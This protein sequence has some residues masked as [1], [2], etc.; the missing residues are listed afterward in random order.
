MGSDCGSPTQHNTPPLG[1]Q[2]CCPPTRLSSSQGDCTK[3]QGRSLTRITQ[4]LPRK[5]SQWC[6]HGKSSG[7]TAKWT[8]PL[9]LLICQATRGWQPGLQL[10]PGKRSHPST[11]LSQGNV[12]W[13]SPLLWHDLASTKAQDRGG[14]DQIWQ[15]RMAHHCFPIF[16]TAL[17]AE[18]RGG[19][20]WY[21]SKRCSTCIYS[22]YFPVGCDLEWLT[23]ATCEG[24]LLAPILLES[25]MSHQ[26][27]HVHN[28]LTWG[29]APGDLV[30]CF[31]Q[32]ES[33]SHA[34]CLPYTP[35]YQ[36]SEGAGGPQAAKH[37]PQSILCQ[38]SDPWQQR[39][40]HVETFKD[41]TPL[42]GKP[43]WHSKTREVHEHHWQRV[44][45]S[46][47][48]FWENVSKITL[49]LMP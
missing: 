18:G 14:E 5:L 32:K 34:A 44:R 40:Q 13:M 10:P 46:L 42:F 3:M 36:Q 24:L 38:S 43:S 22:K 20:L 47:L 48:S 17:L 30:V 41:N 31:L 49:K 23:S 28:I 9:R 11:P 16:H 8:S 45:I 37:S 19:W 1:C 21:I 35:G 12:P 29:A 33:L 2:H 27:W 4:C 25:C 15:K 39:T 26:F 7:S 6:Y